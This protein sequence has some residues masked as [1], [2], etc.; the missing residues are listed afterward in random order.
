MTDRD[1]IIGLLQK[2]GR[3]EID[4]HIDDMPSYGYSISSSDSI[5]VSHGMG[6][7][8]CTTVFYF[9]KDGNLVDHAALR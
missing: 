4:P 1:T 7:N 3:K 8:G 9:G 5:I 6:D 2:I